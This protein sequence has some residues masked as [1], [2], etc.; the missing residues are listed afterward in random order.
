MR[1]KYAPVLN[2]LNEMQQAVAYAVRKSDLAQA[3]SLIVSLEQENAKLKAK[4]AAYDG[5]SLHDDLVAQAQEI[6]KLKAKLAEVK[7]R[8]ARLQRILGEIYSLVM[9]ESPRLLDEDSG[10][11][12]VLAIDIQHALEKNDG[13]P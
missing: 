1:S 7:Q 8:E 2:A 4:L 5:G 9:G 13:K 12:A 10:G 11:D 3:E 6:D